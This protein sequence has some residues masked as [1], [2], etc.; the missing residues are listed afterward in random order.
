MQV[1]YYYH[2]LIWVKTNRALSSSYG[3]FENDEEYADMPKDSDGSAKVA[4][5]GI[6]QSIG[7]WTSLSKYFDEDRTDIKNI[8][9]LL[10]QLRGAIER[11]FPYARAFVRPGFDE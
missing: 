11:T 6:D 8:L 5:L 9:V 3:D 4:L 7:A 2:I 1:A 10:R